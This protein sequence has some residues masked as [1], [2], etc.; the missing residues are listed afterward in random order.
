MGS[1][2]IRTSHVGVA[3]RKV[4]KYSGPPSEDEIV[5]AKR[6]AA[7]TLQRWK[8]QEKS[9]MAKVGAKFAKKRRAQERKER[10]RAAKRKRQAAKDKA[11]PAVSTTKVI[12]NQGPKPKQASKRR[13]AAALTPAQRLGISERELERRL[14]AVRMFHNSEQKSD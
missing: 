1:T 9:R 3:Q 2:I 14:K 7:F 6:A 5:I 4:G 13:A 10:K 8:R 11:I 12:R